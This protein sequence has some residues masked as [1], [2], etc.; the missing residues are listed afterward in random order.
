MAIL[1]TK[2]YQ[3]KLKDLNLSKD[4]QKIL[5]EVL[6][7]LKNSWTHHAMGDPTIERSVMG[8]H[9]V[10]LFI[11]GKIDNRDCIWRGKD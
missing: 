7:S 10:S 1:T 6:T 9:Y 8:I 4:Q 2:E 3:Q 5:E 11:D